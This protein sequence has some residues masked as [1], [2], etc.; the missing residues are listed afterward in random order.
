GGRG[1][2]RGPG[3][4]GCHAS[5]PRGGDDPHPGPPEGLAGAG[6][7]A[8]CRGL[9]VVVSARAERYPEARLRAS[10][11]FWGEGRR[12]PA[13]VSWMSSTTAAEAGVGTEWR[14]PSATTCPFM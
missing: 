10:A 11:R 4:R 9:R 13:S 5:R 3:R 7:R 8:C 14:A 1:T 12:W 6:R 2:L